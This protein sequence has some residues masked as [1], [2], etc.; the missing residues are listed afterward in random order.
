MN[1]FVESYINAGEEITLDTFK[2]VSNAWKGTDIVTG[3]L[4]ETLLKNCG[5]FDY[6]STN[7]YYKGTQYGE[8]IINRYIY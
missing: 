8:I 1:H 7:D 4:S 5:G 3:S 6:D 2:A